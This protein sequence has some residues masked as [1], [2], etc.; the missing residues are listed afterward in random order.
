MSG[1]KS[2]YLEKKVLD[3]VLG[4][5]AYTAPST[6]YVALFTVAPTD[7][8]GGTEVIGGSYLRLAITNNTTN[9]P[10]ATGTSPTTKT[11]GTS[12]AFAPATADW[13]TVT[14]WALFDAISSG[15]MLFWSDTGPA[16]VLDGDTAAFLNGA[17]VIEED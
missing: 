1:S 5:T 12:F 7:A 10:N 16:A 6:V 14:A 9:W 17:I 4:N 3:H 2:D 15:N 11:N 8:G 13:G